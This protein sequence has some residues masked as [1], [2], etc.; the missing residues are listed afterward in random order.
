MIDAKFCC[1]KCEKWEED[2]NIDAICDNCMNEIEENSYQEL[3]KQLIQTIFDQ[4]DTK[5]E[6]V[7]GFKSIE[8]KKEYLRVRNRGVEDS[9]FWIADFFGITEEWEKLYEVYKEKP[10]T[11]ELHKDDTKCLNS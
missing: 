3:G 11:P 1:S 8:E 7:V 6:C 10:I 5:G 2:T 4:W 9:A